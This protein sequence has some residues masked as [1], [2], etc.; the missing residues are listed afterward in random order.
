MLG[1]TDVAIFIERLFKT[2]FSL[3][4]DLG[5]IISGIKNEREDIERLRGMIDG[6]CELT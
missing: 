3:Q 5:G 2:T 4:K 6:Q 1:F